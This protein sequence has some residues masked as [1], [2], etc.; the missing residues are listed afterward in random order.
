MRHGFQSPDDSFIWALRDVSFDIPKGEA[1][2]IIGRNGSGKST[3]LQ[4]IA[5]ITQP[6]S[7]TV[8]KNGTLSA[9]LSAG[10]GFNYELTG[11]ENVYLN[12]AIL[13]LP[14]QR[15]D[16]KFDEIVD[17]SGIREFI[18]T[19]VKRYSSGM[20]VRLA[21]SISVVLDPDILLVDEVLTVGDYQ[22]RQKSLDRMQTYQRSSG[23]TVIFV[24]HNLSAVKAFCDKGIWLEKGRIKA[25]G[26]VDD[27]VQAYL[28][29][30]SPATDAVTSEGITHEGSGE[31][32]ITGLEYCNPAGEPALTFMHGEPLVFKLRYHAADR[33]EYPVFSVTV[34]R[35][36]DNV[37]ATRMHSGNDL[38]VLDS[39]EGAGTV[40]IA[41]PALLL[42]PGEYRIVP[43]VGSLD[44]TT[45]DR[46]R[47]FP[48]LSV[49]T[50]PLLSRAKYR[51]DSS[52]M[53]V[54]TPVE[55]SYHSE[56]VQLEEVARQE[57]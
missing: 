51:F 1:W 30:S 19:P 6:T 39:I 25:L 16:D 46:A 21:F 10:A 40:E 24:S 36:D 48:Y 27:V 23:R 35:K 18:D 53:V 47:G 44:A 20:R 29:D 56:A 28:R 7:G 8:S 43:W 11:R 4:I 3:L 9:M 57:E 31:V 37:V 38:Q 5:N 32:Q 26:D 2:G 55:W 12:G 54:Y 49:L 42:M 45:Y 33:V 50:G 15:I 14:K 52:H 13:G 34:L 41:V 17:F 22:F